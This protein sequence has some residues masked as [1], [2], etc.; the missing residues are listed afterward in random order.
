MAVTLQF[1]AGEGFAIDNISGSGLGFYGDAGFA[2]SVPVSSWQGRSFITSANGTTQGAET[3]NVKYLN[4]SSGILGQTGSGVHIKNIP[5]YLASLQL[6]VLSDTAIQVT[7][8]RLYG[9]DRVSI[10]NAP[11]GVTLKAAE[12]IHPSISQLVVGSGDD[13]WQTIAGTGSYLSLCPSPGPS[14]LFAGNGSNST[15]AATMHDWYVALSASPNSVGS[16]SQFG[17]FCEFEYF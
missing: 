8:G 13:T 7:N 14:G 4:T 15:M 17:V 6:R 1:L 3:D 16:K 10:L 2:A 5:N 9:Y 12:L 11:S